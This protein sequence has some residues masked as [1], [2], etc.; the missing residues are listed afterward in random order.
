MSEE[1]NRKL[2]NYS[3]YLLGR[4]DYSA[5]EMIKKFKE[6]EYD[7]SDIEAV[8]SYIQENNYQSDERFARSYINSKLGAKVGLSKIKS[9]LV[10]EKGINKD[11]LENVLAEYEEGELDESNTILKILQ[12]KY[13]NKD[14]K[15][16]K[17]KS[18][19]FRFLVS[20]GF[21]FDDIKRALAVDPDE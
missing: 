12:T 10:F 4:R 5:K 2:V 18:K 8:M 21:S 16:Q 11:L 6:K 3:L 15:D 1:L 13:R 9:Q 17:E 7:P 20:K 14:L 19:A